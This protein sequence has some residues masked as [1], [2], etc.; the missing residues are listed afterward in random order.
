MNCTRIIIVALNFINCNI[1]LR[2]AD[3]F[4]FV[5]QKLFEVYSICQNNVPFTPKEAVGLIRNI[6]MTTPIIKKDFSRR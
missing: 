1:E 3:V 4:I 6:F 5:F 2:A